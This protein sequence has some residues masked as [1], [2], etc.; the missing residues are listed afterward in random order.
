MS[1]RLGFQYIFLGV[2]NSI[3]NRK[4]QK[5]AVR[6]LDRKGTLLKAVEECEQLWG[7]S[8]RICIPSLSKTLPLMWLNCSIS[9]TPC[10]SIQILSSWVR[11]LKGSSV[12][13]T[14]P[15]GITRSDWGQDHI[16]QTSLAAGVHFPPTLLP[17]EAK[18]SSQ[19]KW[20][21]LRTWL[22]GNV[23]FPHFCKRLD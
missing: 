20:K 8:T 19:K 1:W 14:C 23:C 17:T 22:S 11:L 3:Y 4:W 10:L 21:W 5:Q 9:Q 18:V 12:W 7:S 16:M 13:V 6:N 15:L 2:H